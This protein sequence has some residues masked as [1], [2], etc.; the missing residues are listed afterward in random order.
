[1]NENF[2]SV[3]VSERGTCL[4]NN[5]WAE[6]KKNVFDIKYLF[7]TEP[8]NR[9]EEKTD[10][11]LL[12]PKLNCFAFFVQTLKQILIFFGSKFVLQSKV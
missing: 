1:M 4:K 12:T 11:S 6:A 9:E 3:P 8:F 7:K 5:I 2:F 10:K